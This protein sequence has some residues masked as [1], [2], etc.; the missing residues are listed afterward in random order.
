MQ[1]PG[2]SVDVY[3]GE[4]C[5]LVK[6][7][8][9]PSAVAK[10][11]LICNGFVVG[12]RDSR[13]SDHLCRRRPKLSLKD[14]WVQARQSEDAEKEKVAQASNATSSRIEIEA[15][16]TQKASRR[17]NAKPHE[18]LIDR[19]QDASQTTQNIL[20]MSS[21]GQNVL[22]PQWTFRGRP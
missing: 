20:R 7:R 1:L 4:L 22:I 16:R 9:C 5:R 21:N 13:L 8:N 2:K 3:Y 10:E 14:A 12:L 15:V 17:Y 6:C 11:R 18:M 19:H